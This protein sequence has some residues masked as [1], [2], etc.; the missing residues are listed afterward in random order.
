[1]ASHGA[2][3]VRILGDMLLALGDGGSSEEFFV[4][5]T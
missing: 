4:L 2:A 5:G 3:R 1:M